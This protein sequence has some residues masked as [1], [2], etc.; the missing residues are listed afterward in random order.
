VPDFALVMASKRILHATVIRDHG[1]AIAGPHD[2]LDLHQHR[3]AN[4]KPAGLQAGIVGP[5]LK[6]R[7]SS[8]H[9]ASAIAKGSMAVVLEVGGEV[10]RTGSFFTCTFNTTSLCRAR[11]DFAYAVM[12]M[13]VTGQNV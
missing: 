2:V 12:E 7:A 3:A 1:V 11:L 8:T 10:E 6:S 5:F 9:M 13:I 4:G